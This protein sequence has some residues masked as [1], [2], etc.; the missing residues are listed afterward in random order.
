MTFIAGVL[1]Q[2]VDPSNI[3]KSMLVRSGR[4]NS[5]WR[6]IHVSPQLSIGI[7][8]TSILPEDAF[9]QQPLSDQRYV[10]AGDIRI[11]NRAEL[12]AKLNLSGIAARSMADSD[13]F[14]IA[15]AKWNRHMVQ[16]VIGGF[17]VAVWDNQ[18]H[19]LYLLRDHCGERPLYYACSA[20]IFAFASLPNSLRGIEGMDTGLN[21]D[22]LLH[23]LAMGPNASSTT[24]FNNIFLLPPGHLLKVRDGKPVCSRYWHPMDG[25]TVRLKS[26]EDYVEALRELFETAVQARLRTNSKVG[27][28]LSGGL[29]SSSVTATASKLYKSRLTAFTAV[30]HY[31][32]RDLNPTGRFGNEGP[33]A[34]S[35]AA[36]YPNIDHLLVESSR[37]NLI[38]V[39]EKTGRHSCTPVFN[40]T[41]QLWMNAILDKA[42][43]GGMNVVLQ[44][45]CGNATISFG[46][47]IGLS[48]LVQS[49][50]WFELFRQ[51]RQLRANGHISWRGAAYW[52]IGHSVPLGVRRIINREIRD[53]D[54]SLSPVHPERAIEQNLREKTFQQYFGSE[55]S[56]EV[57]RRRMFDFYDAG[58]MNA[59]ASQGWQIS[60]RDPTQDKRIFEFC[61]SIPIE[62][63][64]V[65]GQSRSL[66]RRAMRD[67]L[68]PGILSCTTRGLQA[69]DW[70]LTMGS[71]RAEMAAELSLI[72][73]SPLARHLLDLERLQ[74]L[75]DTWPASGYEQPSVSNAWHLAL[76]RGLAAGN[77]IRHFETAA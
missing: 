15:W 19:E 48:N 68:P 43:E 46:G 41:N 73:Q 10:L 8:L 20:R 1:G 72:R 3:F 49:G 47:L 61:L 42:K 33:A 70:Y 63:Y 6:S 12:C 58:F 37:E 13:I 23:Y 56:P 29:D 44:G 77:F 36:K 14:L 76:S 40:P 62:Q 11:D 65:G 59:A 38:Q 27:S 22:H 9:D 57:F 71:Q 74:R 39:M 60:L 31:S 21:E 17:A 32:F 26:D 69:A 54:L 24:Y 75:L 25:P 64:L 53:F 28:Q 45:A 2:S 7:S 66:V 51:T 34:A 18:E 67:R 4:S 52:S 55:T 50:S 16:H 30:P 35:I 5:S